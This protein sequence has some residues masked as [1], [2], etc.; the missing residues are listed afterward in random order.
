MKK[1]IFIFL[2]FAGLT[3][4][5]N[6]LQVF[7]NGDLADTYILMG[8]GTSTIERTY[9]RLVD[10]VLYVPYKIRGD[11]IYSYTGDEVVIE[12]VGFSNGT[13]DV[14]GRIITYS[15]IE[16]GDTL[17]IDGYIELAVLDTT[18]ADSADVLMFNGTEWVAN[19]GGGSSLTEEQVED[20]VGGMLGGTET[21]ISVTYQDATGDIDFVVDD[22]NQDT[23]YLRNDIDA[24]ETA[25][26]LNTTHR[27]SNG[28]DH[29]YIDQ[30]V[31]TTG[32]PQFDKLG[33]GVAPGSYD[34]NVLGGANF[35]NTL[36]GNNANNYIDMVTGG[37]FTIK[38]RGSL[39]YYFDSDNNS[40][41]NYFVVATNTADAKFYVYDDSVK[42]KV[43]L[44]VEGGAEFDGNIIA[45]GYKINTNSYSSNQTLTA[46][47]CY[48]SVIYVTGAAT[49]TLPAIADGMSVTIVTVGAVAVSVDPNASDKLVLDGTTLDDGDKATNT[50]TTGDIIVLTYYSAD[51]WYASSNSW[52]DGGA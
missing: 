48:G 39:S 52:T 43:D 34:L 17:Y 25:I 15:G 14:P 35:Q 44:I 5:Q 10:S 45:G 28:T 49:I 1:L 3:Y 41:S 13:I 30:D 29:T 50:S 46:S 31:T 12:N 19:A 2:L 42:T 36:Y 16:G 23:T 8:S 24:N 22:M 37:N 7:K 26:G 33:L 32:T 27:T 40:T 51:G 9:A 6:T 20:Y 4:G 18:G 47:Q 21:N 38:S 11:S